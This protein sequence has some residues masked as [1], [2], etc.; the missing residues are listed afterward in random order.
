MTVARSVLAKFLASF[1]GDLP[2]MLVLASDHV[3][4][5]LLPVVA[6]SRRAQFL[7]FHRDPLSVELCVPLEPLLR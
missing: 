1:L 2:I 5:M 7:E 4:S 3:L 6:F